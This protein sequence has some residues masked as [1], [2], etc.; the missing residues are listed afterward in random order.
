MQPTTWHITDSVARVLSTSL[1]SWLPYYRAIKGKLYPNFIL[2][3]QTMV[4]TDGGYRIIPQVLFIPYIAPDV[5]SSQIP[6]IFSAV[7]G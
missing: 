6:S 1:G 5:V 4:D 7:I 3:G 2:Y